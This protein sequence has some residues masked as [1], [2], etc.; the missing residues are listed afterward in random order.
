MQ[1]R[2]YNNLKSNMKNHQESGFD[3][4]VEYYKDHCTL[5]ILCPGFAYRFMDSCV[6]KFLI[7]A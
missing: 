1:I 2:G 4:P 6:F 5:D 7:T 3:I